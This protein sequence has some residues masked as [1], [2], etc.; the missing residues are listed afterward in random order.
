MAGRPGNK[1]EDEVVPDIIEA[2]TEGDNTERPAGD[3]QVEPDPFPD[4]GVVTGTPVP[5]PEP[6][7]ETY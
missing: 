7:T 2:D 5:E 6:D 4:P 3:W 1:S